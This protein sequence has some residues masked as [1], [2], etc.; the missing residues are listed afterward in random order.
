M[1]RLRALTLIAA[2]AGFGATGAYAAADDARAN[3]AVTIFENYCVVNGGTR[4]EAL[5]R[6]DKTPI[7]KSV[8]EE[9]LAEL[10]S[11]RK[12]GIGW[13]IATPHDGRLI[14][15]Y[16]PIGVCE[17]AVVSADSGAMRRAFKVM[18]DEAGRQL[19][20]SV[21]EGKALSSDTQGSTI[22]ATPY[23]FPFLG[24]TATVTLT[25]AEKTMPIGFQHT[26]TSTFR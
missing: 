22:I 8:P 19:K 13:L 16:D 6:I 3:E 14:L 2:L 1:R 11:G 15:A 17:V 7:A 23:S 25:V 21:V 24:K 9:V 18:V 10:Q 20:V 26:M 5:K 12:G 4:D